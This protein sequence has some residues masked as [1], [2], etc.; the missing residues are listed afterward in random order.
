MAFARGKLRIRMRQIMILPRQKAVDTP[1]A[2]AATTGNDVLGVRAILGTA[3]TPTF[4]VSRTVICV[5]S[6]V[7]RLFSPPEWQKLNTPG[8]MSGPTLVAFSQWSGPK[9]HR[10]WFR[11]HTTSLI[12]PC[13]REVRQR[14]AWRQCRRGSTGTVSHYS[15]G[16]FPY[17]RDK[18]HVARTAS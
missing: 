5:R 11:Q 8:L 7:N 2:I 17:D 13:M 3:R 12:R 15:R 1:L 14:E 18:P 16:G 4:A 10:R 9:L 6:G